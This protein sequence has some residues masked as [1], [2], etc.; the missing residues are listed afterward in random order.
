M[1]KTKMMMVAAVLS[2][3]LLFSS[4]IGSFGLTQKVYNWNQGI[5]G[6]FVNELVFLACNIV[7]VYGVAVWVD[8]VVLNTIEFWSGSNPMAANETKQV[9]GE[10]G[11][12]LVECDEAGYTITRENDE[13]SVRFDFDKESNTWSLASE[14]GNVNLIT[15]VGD[16]QAKMYDADGGSQIVDLTQDGVMA[17]KSSIMNTVFTACK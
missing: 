13:A 6:K 14:E 17:Y 10:D 15:F 1:K 16:N 8:T 3:S 2:G 4:C 12:Y 7:P 5:G 9:Q 11:M